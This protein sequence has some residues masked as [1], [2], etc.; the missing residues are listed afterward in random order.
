MGMIAPLT[1]KESKILAE[2]HAL[3]TYK[4]TT[5]IDKQ[6]RISK[7]VYYLNEGILAMEYKKKQ[8]FSLETLSSKIHQPLYILAFICKSHQDTPY[9]L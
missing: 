5:I 3:K 7:A 8:K 1:P 2:L 4:K 6:G 9:V